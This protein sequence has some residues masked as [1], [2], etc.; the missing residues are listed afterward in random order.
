M[1]AGAGCRRFVQI[2]KNWCRLER[3]RVDWRALALV[4]AAWYNLV[5]TGAVWGRFVGLMQVGAD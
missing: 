1:Q 2:D 3:L 5:R 4:F